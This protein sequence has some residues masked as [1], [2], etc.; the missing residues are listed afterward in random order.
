[1]TRCYLI[2]QVLE[3][4]QLTRRDFERKRRDGKLPFLEELLPRIG[5]RPRY[6]A[7]LI[8]NY[9]AGKRPMLHAVL[10]RLRRRA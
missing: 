6:R 10:P 7:D 5:Q 9:L 3:V 2:P 4:L 1:M 8:D